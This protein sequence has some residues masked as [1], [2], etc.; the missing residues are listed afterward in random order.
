MHLGYKQKNNGMYILRRS[1]MD[2]IATMILNEYMPQVLESPAPVNVRCLAEENYGLL[3]ENRNITIDR[4]ILGLISF[5]TNDLPLY[6]V[7][8]RPIIET[9]DDGTVVIDTSLLGREQRARYRFT[10]AHELAHWLVHRSYR[11]A[12]NQ[13]F[14]LRT[15]NLSNYIACRS[16]NVESCKSHNLTC[17][18]DWEEWQADNLAAAVLMPKETFLWATHDAFQMADVK[19]NYVYLDGKYRVGYDVINE[20]LSR[21][22]EIYLVSLR[23]AQIRLEQLGYF[24]RE[25]KFALSY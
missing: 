20:I 15:N 24:R 25:N 10:L 8:M 19:G 17:D 16:H 18:S 6:D 5:G 12:T 9:V 2:D 11:S 14:Q 23:A 21:I 1:D 13:Q 7:M 3:I 4:T 22:A